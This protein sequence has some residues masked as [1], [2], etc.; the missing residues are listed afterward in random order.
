MFYLLLD[1]PEVYGQPRS[2]QLPQRNLIPGSLWSLATAVVLGLSAL[3]AFRNRG[4]TAKE[5]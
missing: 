4:A 1:E 5:A 3:A 2:P